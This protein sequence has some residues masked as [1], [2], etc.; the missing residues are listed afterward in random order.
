MKTEGLGN[1]A[2]GQFQGLA[3]SKFHPQLTQDAFLLGGRYADTP[4]KAHAGS[5]NAPGGFQVGVEGGWDGWVE[6]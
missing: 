3:A 2:D 6:A 5:S 1:D 4:P